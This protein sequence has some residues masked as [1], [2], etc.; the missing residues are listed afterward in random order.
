VESVAWASERKDV[1]STLF[2]MLTMLAYVAYVER[3]SWRR[4][5]LVVVGL[6]LD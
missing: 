3:P 5:A 2:W 6:V 4:Y 1:L